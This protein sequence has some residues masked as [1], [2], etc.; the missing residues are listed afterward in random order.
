MRLAYAL[1][2]GTA[3]AS[4]CT[5]PSPL[6]QAERAGAEAE[7]LGPTT[8]STAREARPTSTCR[9]L[10]GPTTTRSEQYQL[11]PLVPLEGADGIE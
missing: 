5:L 4:L 6:V 9:S 7:T 10:P 8:E 1:L 11:C 2:T 3:G